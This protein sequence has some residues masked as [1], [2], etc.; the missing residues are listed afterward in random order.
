MPIEMTIEMENEFNLEEG[1]Y[2]GRL[3]TL[4]RKPS[5]PAKGLGDQ[6]RFLFEMNIPS[7]KNRTPMAGRNFHM[8]LKGG[9][10]LRRFLEGWLGKKFFDANSGKT[11][12][13]ELLIGRE[14]D[15]VLTHFQQVGYERPMVCIESA[16]PPG[17]LALTEQPAIKEG[18]D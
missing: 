11:L 6:V 1:Q 3:A 13:L 14:A 17:T 9:S 2:R 18:R 5:H 4:S 12:D 7:I 10:E 8:S 16:A 15:L